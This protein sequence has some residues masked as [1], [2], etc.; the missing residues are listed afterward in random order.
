MQYGSTSNMDV[1]RVILIGNDR[2][3]QYTWHA[4]RYHVY[5]Y[6]WLQLICNQVFHRVGGDL[7]VMIYEFLG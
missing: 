4:S 3:I 6:E 1:V 5:Y 2:S 7:H